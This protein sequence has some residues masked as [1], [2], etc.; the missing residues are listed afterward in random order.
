L[1]EY[2]RGNHDAI[3]ALRLMRVPA[4]EV[5]GRAE[6]VC[7]GLEESKKLRVDVMASESLIGGGT[8]P[9]ATLPT[10]V[11][12][13]THAELSADQLA[14]WLRQRE[15]VIVARVDEGKV[16]LDLRTVF[17][18]DDAAIGAALKAL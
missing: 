9:T 8:A 2:L 12:A 6:G 14:D 15:P 11:L 13:L 1:L 17:P 7:H 10:F 4:L 18:E 16:L 5:R 3:P